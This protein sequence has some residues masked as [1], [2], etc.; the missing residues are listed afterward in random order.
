[1]P[2]KKCYDEVVELI[3]NHSISDIIS[4]IMFYY[5]ITAKE[6][7]NSTNKEDTIR[8]FIAD[9]FYKLFRDVIIDILEI[10]KKRVVAH[11]DE[12]QPLTKNI[13][14]R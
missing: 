8:M 9:D 11:L 4:S 1:M 14:E 12:I 2:D 6:F 10:Y 5:K 3:N 13:D 7:T